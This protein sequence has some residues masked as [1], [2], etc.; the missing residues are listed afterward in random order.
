MKKLATVMVSIFAIL[1]FSFAMFAPAPA[2][3]TASD[4][5][6]RGT[7]E[8]G[9]GTWTAGT[10]GAAGTCKGGNA[11]TNNA[12]LNDTI[13]TVIN[14]MLFIVG[15]L[16]VIMIIYGGIRYVISRGEEK[17]ITGAK[18]TIMYS[19]VGLV[20]AIIAFVI[21]QWVFTTLNN[22]SSS[23]SSSSSSSTSTTP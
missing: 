11:D 5:V 19:I 9:G 23:S 6:Q 8:A 2:F 20:V 4:E 16:A 18:N 15:I 10:G 3:A 13:H 17:E 7:C 12:N 21:V 1:G 14:T 22:N